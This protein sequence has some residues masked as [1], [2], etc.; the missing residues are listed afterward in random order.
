MFIACDVGLKSFVSVQLSNQQL[1]DTAS[2]TYQIIWTC[3]KLVCSLFWYYIIAAW[4][5]L[6]NP[7][8]S[9]VSIS[10]H[11]CLNLTLTFRQPWDLADQNNDRPFVRISLSIHRY[12][13][14]PFVPHYYHDG[15]RKRIFIRIFNVPVLTKRFIRGGNKRISN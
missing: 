14:E 3:F 1:S 5:I 2:L 12:C 6:R 8:S 9:A 15:S 11:Y 13:S 7:A 10:F 4:F